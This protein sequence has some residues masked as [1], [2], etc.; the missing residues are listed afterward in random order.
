MNLDCLSFALSQISNLITNLNKKNFKTSQQE[1]G[2]LVE[3]HGFEAER[4]L[5]RCLVSSIDFHADIKS[6]SKD[7]HQIQLF[8]ECLTV[9]LYKPNFSTVLCYAIENPLQFQQSQKFPANI[10]SQISKLIKLNQLQEIYLAILFKT[11]SNSEEFKS[12]SVEFLN[13]KLAEFVDSSNE[14]ELESL[15]EIPIESLHTILTEIEAN[16]SSENLDQ[17]FSK[18]FKDKKS[19]Q[20]IQ[21]F[22][23]QRTSKVQTTNNFKSNITNSEQYLEIN[24]IKMENSI[25]DLIQELGFSFTASVNDC[26]SA[27]LSF[28]PLNESL[29][30][31]SV[32]RILSMMAR[33]H[34]SSSSSSSSTTWPTMSRN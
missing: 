2:L 16:L 3:K 18:L 23:T 13:Q 22:L 4:Y 24:H 30:P 1:I 19:R 8:K 26:R 33:T 15:N 7:V 28:G 5:F 11:T 29:T 20:I 17:V 31:L 27:L 21:P 14:T 6:T 12:S 10:V 9:S 32:A 34:S 25:V